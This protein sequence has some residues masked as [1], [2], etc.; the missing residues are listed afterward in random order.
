[1][2]SSSSVSKSVMASHSE[3]ADPLPRSRDGRCVA[4]E[5]A[6]LETLTIFGNLEV[7]NVEVLTR[8][9]ILRAAFWVS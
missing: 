9:R 8:I 2:L 7:A 1:M 3:P 5:M 4:V 6:N